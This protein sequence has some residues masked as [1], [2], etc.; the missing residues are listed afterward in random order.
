MSN[1]DDTLYV[2]LPY[3]HPDTP[4]KDHMPQRVIVEGKRFIAAKQPIGGWY[5]VDA[6]F[7]L[8]LKRLRARNKPIF[9]I[10]APDEAERIDDDYERRQREPKKNRVRKPGKAR[11][12]VA[13]ARGETVVDVAEIEAAE[14]AAGTHKPVEDAPP[15]PLPERKPRARRGGSASG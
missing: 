3:R 4:A 11:S 5:E 6:A 7:G 10:A 13:G 1:H 12:V 8:R 14:L 2:R 15:A 9:E